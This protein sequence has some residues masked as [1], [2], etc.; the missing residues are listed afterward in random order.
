MSIDTTRFEPHASNVLFDNS[1]M[2]T[3][4]LIAFVLLIR[5]LIWSRNASTELWKFGINFSPAYGCLLL[6]FSA[7]RLYSSFS[8]YAAP[9]WGYVRTSMA[10]AST[11]T[12][13]SFLELPS[14]KKKFLWKLIH[15]ITSTDI[16]LKLFLEITYIKIWWRKSV[17]RPS[18][19]RAARALAFILVL[20]NTRPYNWTVP[21]RL[22]WVLYH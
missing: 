3:P 14:V 5:I 6:F 18:S 2:F 20:I 19:E 12:W 4:I 15:K 11:R 8:I 7:K 22:K 13:K 10:I 21:N 17:S 16:S 1:S 9:F